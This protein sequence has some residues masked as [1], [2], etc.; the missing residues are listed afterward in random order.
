MQKL[1]LEQKAVFI[2][3][4]TELYRHA[5]VANNVIYWVCINVLYDIID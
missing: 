4:K 1:L 2:V 3:M 5:Y